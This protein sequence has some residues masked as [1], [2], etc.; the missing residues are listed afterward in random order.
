M[1]K[2]WD[3]HNP[4]FETDFTSALSR[5]LFGLV[6][7]ELLDYGMSRRVYAYAPNHELVIKF[8][9]KAGRFQNVIEWET[10]Q[11]VYNT[12]YRDWFAGCRMISP[13]GTILVME[14]T[15]IPSTQAD[16]PKKMPAFFA[17][18]KYENY[19]MLNGNFV[20]HDYGTNALMATGLTKK[21]KKAD[22]WKG[23]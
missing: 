12:E 15:D 8:E 13:C 22:W 21:M 7:D 14:R 5:D 11:E 18:F 9:T 19:G 2:N 1:M 23:S 16:Y 3:T 6:C 4:M 17:D 20:C 10:W